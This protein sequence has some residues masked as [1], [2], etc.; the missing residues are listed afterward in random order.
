M[1]KGMNGEVFFFNERTKST[2]E[3]KSN[4]L[5]IQLLKRQK[6]VTLGEVS[7]DVF[8]NCNTF[9]ISRKSR[10]AKSIAKR[11]S[12]SLILNC[13]PNLFQKESKKYV[14]FCQQGKKDT[15]SHIYFFDILRNR[16]ILKLRGDALINV[17]EREEEVFVNYIKLQQEKSEFIL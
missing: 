9:N 3:G 10:L 1:F 17:Y 13:V 6:E 16:E 14:I 8:Q 15:D 7:R 5:Q 12:S 11:K 4:D 2:V